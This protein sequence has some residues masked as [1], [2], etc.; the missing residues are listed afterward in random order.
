MRRARTTSSEYILK[1]LK[2]RICKVCSPI[3]YAWRPTSTDTEEGG[4]C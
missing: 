4:W 2:S 1:S 3:P